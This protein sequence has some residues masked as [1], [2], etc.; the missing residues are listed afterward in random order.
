MYANLEAKSAAPL[1]LQDVLAPAEAVKL[2]K[3]VRDKVQVPTITS[4]LWHYRTFCWIEFH[5]LPLDGL[6]SPMSNERTQ[7]SP[8]VQAGQLAT[9]APAAGSGVGAAGEAVKGTETEGWCPG[10]AREKPRPGQGAGALITEVLGLQ[11]D[12]AKAALTLRTKAESHEEGTSASLQHWASESE[13]NSSFHHWH[14]EA[15]GLMWE[16][17]RPVLSVFIPSSVTWWSWI[18]LDVWFPC[19]LQRE[20]MSVGKGLLSEK[21]HCWLD[22]NSLH[23]FSGYNF[24]NDIWVPEV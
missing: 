20:L 19:S 1:A 8:R 13:I 4:W 17:A 21:Q 11:G 22:V 18:Y 6:L 3:R 23:S 15:W 7:L 24:K 5:I 16:T 10:P 14:R 9:V 12:A 2:Y